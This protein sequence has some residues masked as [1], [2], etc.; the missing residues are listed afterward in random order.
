MVTE[1]IPTYY[2]AGTYQHKYRLRGNGFAELPDNVVAVPMLNN[3]DPLQ[4][5]EIE[6][7]ANVM[8]MTRISPTEVEFAASAAAAHTAASIGAILSNDRQAVYW[9]NE[10]NPLP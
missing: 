9:V 6:S 8:R 4:L 5:R 1:I 10:T 2:A 3:N 7:A